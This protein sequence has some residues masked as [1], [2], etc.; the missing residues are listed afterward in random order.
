MFVLA[1]NIPSHPQPY[2]MTVLAFNLSNYHSWE[3]KGCH[4]FGIDKSEDNEHPLEWVVKRLNKAS[5]VM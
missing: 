3:D 5:S 4:V 1:A 2:S